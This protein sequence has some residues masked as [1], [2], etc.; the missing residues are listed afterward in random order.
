MSDDAAELEPLIKKLTI[1][2]LRRR[3]AE[4]EAQASLDRDLIL[5]ADKRIAGLIV[6]LRE[7]AEAEA[8]YRIKHDTLGDGHIDAGR[9]WDK[10]RKAGNRAR[11]ALAPAEDHPNS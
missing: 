5:A 10:M 4:L 8:D 1:A 11:A 6:L 2:T 9:A 7:L 3:I